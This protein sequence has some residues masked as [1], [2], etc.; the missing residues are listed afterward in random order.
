MRLHQSRTWLL[1]GAAVLGLAMAPLP[2]SAVPISGGIGF[3]GLFVPTGGTDLSDATGLNVLTAQVT[4][5]TGDLTPT[6]GAS[7]GGGDLFFADFGFDPLTPDPVSPLWEVTVGLDT[8][9]FDLASIS[10]DLQTMDELNLSGSGTMMA[11]GLDDTAGT[12]TFSG[13]AAG[14]V[15]F[16]FSSITVAQGVPEPGTLALLAVGLLGAGASRRMRKGC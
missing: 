14:N 10:I 9:S 7:T 2:A 15:L 6:A 12:W 16:S 5:A 1:A 11:S 4:V 3:G 13:N 8:Y